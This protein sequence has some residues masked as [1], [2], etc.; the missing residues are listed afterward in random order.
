[1]AGSNGNQ[2]TTDQ[3]HPQGRITFATWRGNGAGHVPKSSDFEIVS[4]PAGTRLASEVPEEKPRPGF[5]K[6]YRK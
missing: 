1:M 2:I 6:R 3:I 5:W 4:D